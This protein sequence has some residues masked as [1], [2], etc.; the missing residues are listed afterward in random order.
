MVF[1][2][3]WQ[4]NANLCPIDLFVQKTKQNKILNPTPVSG[5]KSPLFLRTPVFGF[6]ADPNPVWASLV[7]QTVESL[8]A[9]QETGLQSLSHEDPLGKGMVTHSSILVRRI[10]WT[11]EPGGLQATGS[12]RVEQG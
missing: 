1:R 2:G 3:L 8:P 11:E 6:K 7:A 12:K 4:N 10:P 9:R 5:S